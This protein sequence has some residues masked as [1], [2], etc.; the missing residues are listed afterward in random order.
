MTFSTPIPAARLAA[1]ALVLAA[2]LAPQGPAAAADCTDGVDCYC[3]RAKNPSDPLYDP[4]M[5]MCEDFEAITLY[6]DTG[7]GSKSNAGGQSIKGPWY[8]DSGYSGAWGFNSYWTQT[9][10]STITGCAVRQGQPSSAPV[11][12]ACAYDT[13]FAREW[14]PTNRWGVNNRSC[15]DI[16]RAGDADAEVSSLADPGIHDGKQI[17][18]YRIQSGHNAGIVGE[19]KFSC[20]SGDCTEIGV[21]MAVAY[22]S[23]VA[24]SKILDAPWKHEEWGSNGKSPWMMGNMARTGG[25]RALPYRPVMLTDTIPETQCKAIIGAADVRRGDISCSCG[26]GQC[27]AIGWS[28]DAAYYDQ[29]RDWPWGTWGCTRGHIKGLGTTNASVK[30]YHNDQLIVD[31]RNVDSRVF[32]D[33][34]FDYFVWNAYSNANQGLGEGSGPTNQTTYRYADNFHVRTG[35]PA[36]CAAIGFDGSVPPPPPDPGEEPPAAPPAPPILLD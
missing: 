7:K 11:G 20:G 8:D 18:A 30:L 13:C 24:A 1:L 16:Q 28:A 23:N 31:I 36:S 27:V 29:A 5:V 10:G 22:A 4:N 3:D 15:I 9:Y 14:H 17:F 19:K 33:K 34:K 32:K 25:T 2:M 21:T 26:G 12:S 35:P 6:E